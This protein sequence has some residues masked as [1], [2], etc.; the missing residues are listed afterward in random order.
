MMPYCRQM[1]HLSIVSKNNGQNLANVIQQGIA[2]GV[3]NS[4]YKDARGTSAFLL[5]RDSG[6][7]NRILDVNEI[8]GDPT[9][10]SS[11]RAELG[12][13]F[14]I[15]AIADCVVQVQKLT[16]GKIK[17]GLD[18]EQAMLDARGKWPLKPGQPNYDMLHAI[19]TKI[20]KSPI[21][22]SFFWI[23]SHQDHKGKPLD[24]WALLNI[25]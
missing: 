24:N 15:L 19:R 14:G 3:S 10:Q 12:G 6:E 9:E 13:I 5:E 21:S 8:P 25:I 16:K 23:E 4:S 11:Y 18:H 20:K 1:G 7:T 2:Y 17:V 22:W